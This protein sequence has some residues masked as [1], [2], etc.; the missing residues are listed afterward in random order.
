MIF[1]PADEY[2]E[3]S[4]PTIQT[5]L[6]D[7][8]SAHLNQASSLQKE[9]DNNPQEQHP[10]PNQEEG[11]DAYGQFDL[12]WDDPMVLAALNDAAEPAPAAVP[13][14]T[15]QYTYKSLIKVGRSVLMLS[16]RLTS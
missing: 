3:C 14:P 15:M 10:M 7:I 6:Q 13:V 4:I 8:V 9:Q 16:I 1:E 5:L 12:N 2:D 11:Q